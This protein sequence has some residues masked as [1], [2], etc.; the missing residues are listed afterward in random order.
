MLYKISI[1][2]HVTGA[3]LFFATMAMEWLFISLLRKE[4]NISRLKDP[5]SGYAKQSKLGG[6]SMALMLITGVYMTATVWKETAWIPVALI[7]MV[8][9]G[10]IGGIVTGRRM[11]KIKNIV[12]NNASRPAENQLIVHGRAL[13]YSLQTRTTIFFGIILLMTIKPGWTGSI[14]TIALSILIGAIPA[15]SRRVPSRQ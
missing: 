9:I 11:K 12:K 10:A 1:F 5:L 2:L 4:T 7:S 6:A 13:R 14:I 3:L 15:G 8:L